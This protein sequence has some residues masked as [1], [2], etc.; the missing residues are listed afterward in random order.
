MKYK[1]K[2]TPLTPLRRSKPYEIKRR[3]TKSRNKTLQQTVLQNINLKILAPLNTRTE[4]DLKI[5]EQGTEQTN[6][7]KI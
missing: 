1:A 4:G 3:L 2:R 7:Y 5:G 6:G